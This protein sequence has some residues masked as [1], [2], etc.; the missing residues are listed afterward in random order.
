[1]RLIYR[2]WYAL[3]VKVR[4][5]SP[6]RLAALLGCLAAPA[7]AQQPLTAEEFEAFTDGATIAFDIDGTPYGAETYRPNRR[8][9]W[10]FVDG[11]T[12]A[13]CVDGVWYPEGDKICFL[14]EN[15]SSPH[16]WRFFRSATGLS[17]IFVSDAENKTTYSAQVSDEP[18]L[19]LGPEIGA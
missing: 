7:A 16:C 15:E 12:P 2:A 6:L 9:T 1:M 8:V 17:G 10:S 11:Q 13:S 19:C 5:S 14:Y 3:R 18:L 4:T